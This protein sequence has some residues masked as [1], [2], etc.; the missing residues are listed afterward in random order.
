MIK[1]RLTLAYICFSLSSLFK[2]VGKLMAGGGKIIVVDA[3]TLPGWFV[4]DD[5]LVHIVKSGVGVR[6]DNYR[7]PIEWIR[8]ME[9]AKKTALIKD[10]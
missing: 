9:E 5:F 6:W 8:E 10:R 4:S 3:L 1:I 2:G 7:M